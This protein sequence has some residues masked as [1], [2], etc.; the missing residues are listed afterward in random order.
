MELNSQIDDAKK[1]HYIP[2]FEALDELVAKISGV[3]FVG[4]SFGDIKAV[5]HE[6][7]MEVLCQMAQSYLNQC[8]AEEEKRKLVI[9]E[10]GK[11]RTHRIWLFQKDRIPFY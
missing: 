3:E 9:G 1:N 8:R 6:K 4:A 7:G 11:I 2:A 10:D 5:I